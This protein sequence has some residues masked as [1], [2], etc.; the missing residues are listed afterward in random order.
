[1]GL[2]SD[3]Y[4]G[5]SVYGKDL[6]KTRRVSFIAI[7][8]NSENLL[9]HVAG[10]GKTANKGLGILALRMYGREQ[11]TRCLV[12]EES[13]ARAPALGAKPAPG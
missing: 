11:L 9:D 7:R 4:D 2:I 12:A 1:V 5:V 8:F 10:F 13:S 3:S 6:A